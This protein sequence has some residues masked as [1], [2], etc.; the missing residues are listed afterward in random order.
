MD[1]VIDKE[2][3]SHLLRLENNQQEKVLAYMKDLLIQD[4]MNKRADESEK[5]ISEGRTKSFDQ[6]NRSFEQWK[7]NKRAS[8]K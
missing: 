2:L 7:A 4:E 6:F 3:I 1:Q 5:A 8:M